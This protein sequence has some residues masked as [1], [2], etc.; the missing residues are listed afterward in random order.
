MR[1]RELHRKLRFATLLAVGAASFTAAHAVVT[2]APNRAAIAASAT[3]NWGQLGPEFTAVNLPASFIAGTGPSAVSGTV[4]GSAT[5]YTVFTGSTFNADF[6]PS[7]NVLTLF[8]LPSGNASAGSFVLTFATPV[9]A[10]GAQVQANIAGGF[11][12]SVLAFNAAGSMLGNFTVNGSNGQNGNGSAAFAGIISDALDIKS[13]HF[14]GFGVGAG[15]N[16]LSL[17]N[18]AQPIPEPGAGALMLAGLVAVVALARRRL[19]A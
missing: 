14:I 13:L 17:R 15:I 2:Q 10:A 4:T 8:D 9:F 6:L 3:A 16:D 7:D 19:K 12:G 5:T 11:V 1:A 18:V